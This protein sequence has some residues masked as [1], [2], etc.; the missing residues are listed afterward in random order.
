MGSPALAAALKDFGA[1]QST[2]SEAFSL[3]SSFP[4]PGGFEPPTYDEPVFEM[5]VFPEV[6]EVEEI[7]VDALIAEAV[8]K[9]EAALTDKL[10]TEHTNA[11]QLARDS[12]ADEIEALQV[13]FAQETSVMVQTAIAEMETRV[14]D[15][16]TTVAARILGAVLTDD[17]RDRSLDRLT[18]LIHEALQDEEAVRIKV[19]GS[20]PLYESLKEKL[21][22]YAEQFDFVESPGI[23]LTVAIFDSIFETRLA[24]WSTAL[25]E[26]LA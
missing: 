5:P 4:A 2:A 20:P 18:G 7:D 15:L 25:A 10:N 23:D 22:E 17:V 8:A 11:M 13:R 14:V 16:T 12:H 26:A 21:P 3:P 24:E 1:P 9:A 19:S 6:P